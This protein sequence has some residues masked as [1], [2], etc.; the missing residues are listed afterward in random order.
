MNA[1]WVVGWTLLHFI[2]QAT[3]VAAALVVILSTSRHRSARFR[4]AASVGALAVMAALPI[5]TAA[6]LTR[7]SAGRVLSSATPA[8]DAAVM[9]NDARVDMSP[10]S[11]DHVREPR[12]PRDAA[13]IE[14]ATNQVPVS[15]NL[16]D[17]RSTEVV[18][19]SWKLAATK[20]RQWGDRSAPALVFV[21]LVGV[22]LLSI[23]FLGGWLRVGRLARTGTRPATPEL[24]ERLA[25]L[26]EQLRL[27]R[28]VRLLESA[29]VQVPAVV[30]W[31]KPVVLVPFTFETGLTV[32][33]LELLLAHELA[34][35]RRHDYL[36]NILQTVVETVLFYHPA[37]WWVSGRIRE[38][39]EHCCDDV[40]VALC[41]DRRAYAEALLRLEHLRHDTPELAV[42]AA[43]GSLL[44]RIR[45]LVVAPAHHAES[46]TRWAALPLG[47]AAVVAIA[48]ASRVTLA[49][50][51]VPRPLPAALARPNEFASGPDTLRNDARGARP[52]TVVRYEGPAASLAARWDWATAAA[53]RDRRPAFWIGYVIAGDPS[54]GFLYVD[55][56]VP[57]W[58]EHGMTFGRTRFT[59][60][61]RNAT[62]SGVKLD[63]LFGER[64]PED[65][66]VL[67]G[68]VSRNGRFELD[69]VHV[70]NY[71]LPAYFARRAVYWL[72]D[73][74][75]AQSIA[76]AQRLFESTDDIESK[77]DLVSVVGAHLDGDAVLPVL[78][79][80]LESTE[81]PE[82]RADVAE[83]LALVDT[84]AALALAA[85][86]AR[87]DRS[88]DVRR[89]AAESL[90]EFKLTE[91][92][93]T[94]V[95]LARGLD[96]VEVR[97]EAVEAL[98]E[99]REPRALDALVRI[100]REDR[101]EEVQREAVET[102]GELKDPRA[103]AEL[104]RI[105][106][107]HPNV[108][109]RREAVETLG[110]V[111][112]PSQSVPFLKELVDRDPSG[113]VRLEA[114]ETLG[115]VKDE[116][117][118][119]LL[120]DLARTHRDAEVRKKAVEALA[121]NGE[122]AAVFDVL[123]DLVR[124]D[125]NESAQRSAVEALGDLEDERAVSLL[126]RVA[127]GGATVDVQRAAAEALG[128]AAPVDRAWEA[129]DRL[130]WK[131]PN[132]EVQKAAVEALANIE[133]GARADVFAKIAA[134][135]PRRDVRRA[136]VEALGDLE[137]DARAKAHLARLAR[138]GSDEELRASA[139][140]T[141]P[142]VATPA[143]VVALLST[144]VRA[145]RSVDLQEKALETLADLDD[146][147]GLTAVID[148][149]RS[150]PNPDMR[151]KAIEHLGD[152]DDPRA[153]AELA[154]LLKR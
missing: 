25:A 149:A 152:S 127:S 129:L 137:H 128:S 12:E 133:R 88:R 6:R 75:D 23:R 86:T 42:A 52:D 96:D 119:R 151:R 80:W 66:A 110:E 32:Q 46:R 35:I 104:E 49:N 20:L 17:A 117:A 13:A 11:D 1:T 45:R 105:A 64:P 34:H 113:D 58:W 2:W 37:V 28:P 108:E 84:P 142:N 3:A 100:A 54:R 40:A 122:K 144:I 141:Y 114:V 103:V 115:E 111:E 123:S 140:E 4:Y 132:D 36:V 60:A 76:Q 135:H 55:R 48:G 61:P 59:E 27:T 94:L 93:D 56:N 124:D 50:T 99:R 146:N 154:K 44:K 43:G 10:A 153:H 73:A 14:R 139:I 74:P 134:D 39:R 121:E 118:F 16:A 53:R 91:A 78:R 82:L 70:G 79:R 87:Q 57:I 18:S 109:V 136:A 26:A 38:E 148:V 31:L 41:R 33:E 120:G 19:A 90:G 24:T 97:K 138:E 116:T 30:G 112:D 106:R 102:M 65:M 63:A 107:S 126:E 77:K 71:V 72:N 101:S 7:H 98:G 131:H 89:E 47:M 8:A 15:D 21:W 22:V 85:R 51:G 130:V 5:V 125:A 145:D 83:A 143:E 150:H 147:A 62:F 9:P 67:Y 69:R 81:P 95:D 68:F 92:A 29:L